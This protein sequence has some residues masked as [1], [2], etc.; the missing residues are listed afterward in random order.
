MKWCN[1]DSR[2]PASRVSVAS[3]LWLLLATRYLELLLMIGVL[4]IMKVL[5]F[6]TGGASSASS[7]HGITLHDLIHWV[8]DYLVFPVCL[9]AILDINRSVLR[10]EPVRLLANFRFAARA[11]ITYF[12][13]FVIES[14]PLGPLLIAVEGIMIAVH[15]LEK[16][17][18]LFHLIAFLLGAAI[19]RFV[20]LFSIPL[21]VF[22]SVAVLENIRQ[23]LKLFNRH[24]ARLLPM[25]GFSL[26]LS[27]IRLPG[28]S[29][30]INRSDNL[31]MIDFA[32]EILGI[33]FY[34]LSMDYYTLLEGMDQS[35]RGTS[36]ESPA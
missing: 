26:L 5:L 36:L 10:A 33:L 14:G 27:A 2:A 18:L 7:G 16:G 13:L 12:I 15:V 17:D 28:N 25:L 1:R 11:I 3:K 23:S 32:L 30:F 35:V 21:L 34:V 6:L 20:F 29:H 22:K 8:S 19:V 31:L 4:S 24:K 9:L